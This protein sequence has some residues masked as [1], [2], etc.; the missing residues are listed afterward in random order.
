MI[1]PLHGVG[2]P[3]RERDRLRPAASD[4]DNSTAPRAFRNPAP[5][6]S[7][8]ARRSSAVYCR[9]AFTRFGVSAGFAC[10]ISA[11]VPVTT[12]DALL[13]P[14][15]AR[16]GSVAVRIVPQSRAVGLVRYNVLDGSVSDSM[17]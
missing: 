10:T 15:I 8:F 16:Y 12:G 2:S 5:C 17:P 11:I 14:L 13:V 1:A 9:I 3:S 6:A 7:G 4:R